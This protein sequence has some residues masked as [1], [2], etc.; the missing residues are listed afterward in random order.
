MH[1]HLADPGGRRKHLLPLRPVDVQGPPGGDEAGGDA[2][3]RQAARRLPGRVVVARELGET[4]VPGGDDLLAARE[5]E[6]GPA[7]GLRRRGRVRVPAPDG[8][9]DLA[10]V[11][12]GGCALGLAKRAAHAG[13][14]PIRARAGQHLVD[15]QDV[16]GVDADAQ[17]E[18]VL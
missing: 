1:G 7:Q 11:D 12:A 9:E 15:A 18:G 6:L 8:E 3:G 13:L 5:L 4:P 2:V 17:V 10:D 14:Q 16:E